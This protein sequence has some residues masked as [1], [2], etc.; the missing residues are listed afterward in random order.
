MNTGRTIFSQL[1]DFSPLREFRQCVKRYHGHYKMKSFSCWDQFL[2][3]AFARL[4]QS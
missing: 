2:C 3:L 4:R 1:M